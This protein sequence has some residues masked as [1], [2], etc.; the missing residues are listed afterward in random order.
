MKR[1]LACPAIAI[2]IIAMSFGSARADGGSG[3][4]GY[5]WS[6][7]AVCTFE[8]QGPTLVVGMYGTGTVSIEV[9][10]AIP[11]VR[12]VIANCFADGGGCVGGRGYNGDPY[13]RG[14]RLYCHVSGTSGPK[15]ACLSTT[16]TGGDVNI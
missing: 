16:S 3:C 6:S 13:P 9:D 12:Q 4:T 14:T 5:D 10:S 11:G 7:D 8:Y 2:M 1:F 15:Y